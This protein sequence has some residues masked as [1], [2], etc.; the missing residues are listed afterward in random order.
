MVLAHNV[1]AMLKRHALGTLWAGK[2][3]KAL[4]YC[5]INIPGRV[6]RR[7]RCLII[8]LAQDHPSYALLFEVRR[9]VAGLAPAAAGG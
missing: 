3:M 2:R 1:N 8:R 7:S 6:V 4:R 5:S 9:R